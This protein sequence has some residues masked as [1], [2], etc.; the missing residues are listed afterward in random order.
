MAGSEHGPI[1]LLSPAAKKNYI[2]THTRRRD[3]AAE[4]IKTNR[5]CCFRRGRAPAPVCHQISKYLA[6]LFNYLFAAPACLPFCKWARCIGEAH[7]GH[8]MDFVSPKRPTK[9]SLF[10]FACWTSTSVYAVYC[11]LL[12]TIAPARRVAKRAHFVCRPSSKGRRLCFFT[13]YFCSNC[14]PPWAKSLRSTLFNKQNSS[15]Q[16]NSYY[17]GNVYIEFH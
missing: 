8:F 13:V 3:K 5:V 2:R 10:P 11:S 15:K 7:A 6:S 4:Q 12:F 1:E 9:I 17:M 16:K 14:C